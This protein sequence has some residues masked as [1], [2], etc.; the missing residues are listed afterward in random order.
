MAATTPDGLRYPLPSDNPNIPR[1]IGYLAADTQVAL[2]RLN[3]DVTALEVALRSNV[4][5][6]APF[7]VAL[8][9]DSFIGNP[10]ASGMVYIDFRYTFASPPIVLVAPGNFAAAAAGPPVVRNDG[11]W[12][13][14]KTG[15]WVGNLQ[16]G[17]TVEIA[18]MAL[19]QKA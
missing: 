1:D 14:T 19:G 7:S 18:W 6:P 8:Q 15:C 12:A 16:P 13:K 17:S 11:Q 5:T 9:A 10:N 2:T 4:W 3:G